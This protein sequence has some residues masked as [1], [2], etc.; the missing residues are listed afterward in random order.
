[1]N[2]N[3]KFRVW[4]KN[5][6]KF[7]TYPCYFN[8]LDFNEFTCFERYFKLDE[9]GC[10]IQQ[11]TGLKDKNEKEIYEG[12]IIKYT[13]FNQKDYKDTIVNVPDLISFHWFAELQE[14]L[15]ESNKCEIEVIGNIFKNPELLK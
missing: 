10:F 13:P 3:I 12:D 4:D 2:E 9:D 11:F 7:L 8:H 14:M 6:K 15:Q 1:M 5:E